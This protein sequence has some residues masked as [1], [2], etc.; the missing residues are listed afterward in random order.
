MTKENIIDELKQAYIKSH[1]YDE[2]GNARIGDFVSWIE[3]YDPEHVWGLPQI[4]EP[5]P[6]QYAESADVYIK[7]I[8]GPRQQVPLPRHGR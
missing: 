2:E 3:T 8:Q 6:N 7:Q 5:N 4:K 1:C